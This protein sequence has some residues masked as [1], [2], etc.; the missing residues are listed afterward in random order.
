MMMKNLKTLQSYVATRK[1]NVKSGVTSGRNVFLCCILPIILLLC[2]PLLFTSDVLRFHHAIDWGFINW[3]LRYPTLQLHF[4]NSILDGTL[5]P[6]WLPELMAYH[7]Y[8]T[9]IFYPPGAFFFA[10]PFMLTQSPVLA[11][12]LA[13]TAI[14]LLGAAGVFKLI[15]YHSN[16]TIA[17]ICT[18][19][20]ITSPY[21]ITTLYLRA[22]YAELLAMMLVPWVLYYNQKLATNIDTQKL[23][24]TAIKLSVSLAALCYAHPF[25]LIHCAL[26][27]CAVS[28]AHIYSTTEKNRLFA[29]YLL[30]VITAIA[31]SAPYWLH[32]IMLKDAINSSGIYFSYPAWWQKLSTL[33][34]ANM[35]LTTLALLGFISHYKN[36][37]CWALAISWL[38]LW[39]IQTDTSKPLWESLEILKITQLPYRALSVETLIRVLGMMYALLWI[40]NRIKS[41]K[42]RHV[43]T[44]LALLMIIAGFIYKPLAIPSKHEATAV[45]KFSQFFHEYD[46]AHYIKQ[47]MYEMNDESLAYDFMP[48]N[49]N[50]Q[51][52]KQNP[53][54]KSLIWSSHPE[55]T[56]IENPTIQKDGK[57]YAIIRYPH[58]AFKNET[59]ITISFRQF[60]MPG[61][62]IYINNDFQPS[63]NL[64]RQYRLWHL[65]QSQDGML[66]LI[67][68]KPG[69]Y[70]LFA[71]YDGP[72]G[73]P[74]RN[75][76]IFIIGAI[77]YISFGFLQKHLKT[78]TIN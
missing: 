5:Y 73:W 55:K 42:K 15:K 19:V 60:Y 57:I 8:P 38:W 32:V 67:I 45:S 53:S 7:G 9:F 33:I 24:V 4:T 39:F 49:V 68:K 17:A 25:V 34:T 26:P 58:N 64:G 74:T 6:R 40:K 52:L 69:Q 77:C 63:E 44:A 13:A 21:V 16:Q 43:A 18:A 11:W 28:F 50:I 78:Q 35:G 70:E 2:S 59:P 47:Q 10:L 66:Q 72:P 1:A 22:S 51:E 23:K 14:I 48:K 41:Q 65:H 76:I 12:K 20:F 62:Q 27:L 54:C 61:W 3:A 71:R 37:Q 31:L 46:H 30:C 29:A 36:P 56:E 75:I